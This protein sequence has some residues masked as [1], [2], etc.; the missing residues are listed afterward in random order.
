MTVMVAI[1]CHDMSPLIIV[2]FGAVV[3]Y[4]L[5]L[6]C[7]TFW[8]CRVV[9]FGAVVLYVLVLSC[10]LCSAGKQRVAPVH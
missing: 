3:L 4:V 6:S 9:R 5:V 1:S 7:C 10:V 8:C 2:R